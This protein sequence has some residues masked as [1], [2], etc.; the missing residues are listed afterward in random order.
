MVQKMSLIKNIIAREVLDSR[1]LPTV[2][3]EITLANGIIGRASVPSGAST[4]T[5]EALELRDGGTRFMGKG[6]LKAI[7]HIEND[8]RPELLGR[9]A[10]AQIDIDHTMI[11]LDGTRNKAKLGA[12]A[13]LAVSIAV[14]R[15]AAKTKQLSFYSYL[16]DL[17]GGGPLSL[18]MPMMNVINGGAH[19][20]NKLSFQEFM[21]IPIG[22]LNFNEAMR[23]GVEVFY[24][25]KK[26]LQQ[27]G[28]AT[29]VGDEGGFAPM[30]ESNTQTLDLLMQAITMAGLKPEADIVLAID[31]ASSEFY[32]DGKYH[33]PEEGLQLSSAEMVEYYKNLVKQYP[34][35][36]IEDGLSEQDWDGWQML[37]KELGNTIQIVG[38]DIF[39]TNTEIFKQGIDKHIANAILIKMNQIGTLTET[40]AAIKMAQEANY[41]TIISHRSGETEDC[42]IADLAVATN[43]KQIK[44]GSL[45]RTDRIAKYNRLLRIASQL[46]V[47]AKFG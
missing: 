15:A 10:F 47:D 19:A 26:Q 23:Y 12:N 41:H 9:S 20:D 29:A 5:R 24:A 40:F 7:A 27:Q 25:L 3:A 28:F 30:L 17:F 32:K 39:V 16:N 45:S 1:G 21:I 4:G 31:A 11:S 18:P 37:T 22:A 43:A 35:R 2:E 36:S 34:L 8:I 33:L 44:T 46:G 42:T 6:V 13:I 14:A 38:D